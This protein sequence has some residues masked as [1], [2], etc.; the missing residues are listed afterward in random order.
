MPYVS[1][2]SSKP[3]AEDKME[4]LQKGIGD[5]ISII[6][7]KDSERCM[8]QILGDVKTY[9]GGKP[10]NATFCE[11]RLFG[12]AP[13]EAKKEFSGELNKLMTAELGEIET[14]FINIQQYFEWGIG[15]MYIGG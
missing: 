5:I 8:I 14:F 1:I 9:M 10:K 15:E 6:P 13:A 11:V 2:R 3:I 12:E 4:R 7:G